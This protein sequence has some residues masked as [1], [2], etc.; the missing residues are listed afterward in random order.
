MSEDCLFL[1]IWIPKKLALELS[2]KDN[3]DV[4]KLPVFTY[5]HGGAFIV[6]GGT[7]TVVNGTSFTSRDAILVSMNYRLGAFGFWKHKELTK[8]NPDIP[9][10]FGL[11]D[12]VNFFEWI[13]Q[14]IGYFGGDKNSVT[15]FGESAGAISILHHLTSKR[16]LDTSK[17]K[18]FHKAILSN[19]V[20][21]SHNFLKLEN[22][23]KIGDQL[24][25]DFGCVSEDNVLQCMKSLEP[26]KLVPDSY[27]R[28][29]AFDE[30]M[31]KQLV[32]P[33]VDDNFPDIL[34]SLKSGRFA[35]DVPIIMGT[36][37]DEGSLFTWFTFPVY[38]PEMD[39]LEV[40]LDKSFPGYKDSILEIYK[41]IKDPWKI[42]SE[43]LGDII[44]QCPNNKAIEL[45]ARKSSAPIR[46][47][48][49]GYQTKHSQ[50]VFGVFHCMEIAF[51]FEN[52]SGAYLWP[53]KFTDEE[54]ELAKMVA[55][56][57]IDFGK[58]LLTVEEW[59]VYDEDQYYLQ[60]GL[61]DSIEIRLNNSFKKDVCDFW[62]KEYPDGLGDFPKG[63]L[64]HEG[65]VSRTINELFWKL[66]KYMW[67]LENNNIRIGV[68]ISLILVAWMLISKLF[69]KKNP[70]LKLQ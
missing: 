23:E 32:F 48:V 41:G 28:W 62:F 29:S 33:A 25:K 4:K 36:S 18:L 44:W 67:I 45:L 10:N 13:Q 42:Y 53:T 43:V 27:T 63:L 12:Q 6:G 66:P 58:G 31:T 8:L 61:N 52:P 3:K 16:F 1:N 70:K 51:V 60:I 14:Y 54:K 55:D 35:K 24:A 39:F 17:P 38:G 47:Y 69:I 2:A 5:L 56:L 26:E 64:S 20:I 49:F 57:W 59:P 22:A 50:Q 46:K 40:I 65:I 68:L 34:E 9:T 21:T 7:S 19:T 15:A 30:E 37:I 11:F